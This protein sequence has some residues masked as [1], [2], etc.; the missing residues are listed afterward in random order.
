MKTLKVCIVTQF[1]RD[2]DRPVGGVEAVSVN[3]VRYLARNP[4]LDVHVLSLADIQ[5]AEEGQL[6]SARLHFLPRP[7]GSML[8][9]AIDK[10]RR[11]VLVWLT[12]NPMD[13]VHAHDTY[14]LMVR[15]YPGHRVFT[16]HGFIYGDT[17]VSGSRFATPRAH[18]W[19]RVETRGWGDQPNIVSISPYV[20]E[21]VS[22]FSAARIRDIDN[23]VAAE[24]F[25]IP[26]QPKSGTIFSAAVI[27]PRKNTLKL[28][29]AFR[30]LRQ[31]G[32]QAELRLAGP[33]VDAAYGEQLQQYMRT[34]Q[35]ETDVHLLDSLPSPEVRRE[36]AACSVFALASLEENSPMG[37]EEAMAVGIPVVSSN[38]CGMPY[39]IRH[40]E[41]G[42]LFDPFDADDIASGLIRLLNDTVLLR[43]MGACGRAIALERFHPQRV[44]ARTTDF[45]REIVCRP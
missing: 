42:F 13:L 34:H 22:A 3:L 30:V 26:W 41:S 2:P 6:E 7:S 28:V 25:D 18:L 16:V 1:P 40:G 35:L 24:F 38:R 5:S 9:L 4:E 43:A 15:G 21:R 27:N 17:L 45:Y 20:R 32:V 31:Q 10:G 14:G 33:I 23:P 29:E 36:L 44:A 39:M 12:A 8:R 19:K 11:V 37:I